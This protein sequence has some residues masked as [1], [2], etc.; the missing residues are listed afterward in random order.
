MSSLDSE[1][2]AR[3]HV[4]R[5]TSWKSRVNKSVAL[6]R[7]GFEVAVAAKTRNPLFVGMATASVADTI[8]EFVKEKEVNLDK[9]IRALGLLPILKSSY[10]ARRFL[11]NTLV[12][13]DLPRKPITAGKAK[14]NGKNP[15]PADNV[16][17]EEF[18]LAGKPIY[19]VRDGP[20]IDMLYAVGRE[21]LLNDLSDVLQEGIGG[22]IKLAAVV[23]GWVLNLVLIPAD[24]DMTAYQSP[25]PV[26][27]FVAN[28]R[29]YKK[30]GLNRTSLLRGPPG[31]GKTTF[32][33]VVAEAL[34]ERLL[35]IE[36]VSLNKMMDSGVHMEDVISVVRPGVLLFDDLDR[37]ERINDMFGVVEHLNRRYAGGQIVVMAAVNDPEKI[38][39]PLRRPGRLDEA[40]LFDYPDEAL[41]EDILRAHLEV[42]GPRFSNGIVGKV[43]AETEKFSGADLREVALQ[44]DIHGKEVIWEKIEEMRAFKA[45]GEEEKDGNK[46]SNKT[47]RSITD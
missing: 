16:L 25:I 5:S 36:A 43:V 37:V 33:A 35:V 9:D 11:Y 27:T 12:Q 2:G 44:L 6:L 46:E 38:P 18:I 10:Q 24:I 30:R 22:H 31:T 13:L 8:M 20:H 39:E 34:G 45:L 41:R 21:E 3:L 40:P 29:E 15:S 23:E 14:G 28:I 19:T 42:L 1:K 17:T 7:S 32:A 47:L 26:D 4:G